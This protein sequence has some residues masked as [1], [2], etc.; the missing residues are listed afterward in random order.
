MLNGPNQHI[1]F[2]RWIYP[3]PKFLWHMDAAAS[4]TYKWENGDTERDQITECVAVEV[5]VAAVSAPRAVPHAS[6][7]TTEAR[8]FS[9]LC[10]TTTLGSMGESVLRLP[11]LCHVLL[12]LLLLPRRPQPWSMRSQKQKVAPVV[13]GG[14]RWGEAVSA[15]EVRQRLGR[16]SG[17]CIWGW[18][19]APMAAQDGRRR[20]GRRRRW[21][22]C[23]QK[24]WRGGERRR[25]SR[26]GGS[27]D[28]TCG[29]VWRVRLKNGERDLS[30]QWKR[31]IIMTIGLWK[32]KLIGC[33]GIGGV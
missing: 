4:W 29:R 22:A 13:W 11:T 28:G 27:G 3:T 15:D 7:I 10:K 2:S 24:R 32:G 20:A 16:R 6:S 17:R 18:G 19:V 30:N 25:Q 26:R 21:R 33:V 12:L 23:M 14:L 8:L 9:S 1:S 31:R 5:E